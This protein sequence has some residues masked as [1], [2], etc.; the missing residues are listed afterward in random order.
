MSSSRL[1]PEPR[2]VVARRCYEVL[3]EMRIRQLNAQ[4]DAL[5]SLETLDD[6]IERARLVKVL[7]ELEPDYS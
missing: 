4:I 2:A 7:A 3:I 5:P 6:Y 1:Q